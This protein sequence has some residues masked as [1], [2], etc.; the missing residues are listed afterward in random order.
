[1]QPTGS[2]TT[3][4]DLL[5]SGDS[6]AA[7]Y[8]WDRYFPQLVELARER[9]SGIPRRAV[10]EEDVALS[11]FKSF[12][13]RAQAGRFP[14][15]E[16]RTDLWHLLVVITARKAIDAV[17]KQRSL[18]E[19]GGKVDDGSA[20][21]ALDNVIGREP[22]PDFAAA[23]A[24]ECRDLLACLAEDLRQ[25]ALWKMESY[26]NREIADQFKCAEVTV[27][28]KLKHIRNLWAARYQ[29]GQ[30]ETG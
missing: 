27:E 18:R 1:M 22:S 2:V 20:W 25:V 4:L 21:Q 11:A 6:R 3:W 30:S 16:D 9:L 7:Q 10:D 17:N 15:L 24:D 5:Q 29:S 28:R 23:V 19:G 8:L 26:T 14:Q 12:C 13:L